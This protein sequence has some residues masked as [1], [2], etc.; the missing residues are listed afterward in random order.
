MNQTKLETVFSGIAGQKILI[1]AGASGIGYAIAETLH[2]LGAKLMICDISEDALDKAQERLEGLETIKADVSNEADVAQ[3]F[4]KLENRLGGLD[5]LINNAGIAGPTGGVEDIS[6]QDWRKCLDVCLTGQ[7][8]CTRLAVPLLKAAGAGSII[9]MSSAAG[10]HGYAFRTPYSSAKF[11]VI[12][13]TQSLAKEL[14]PHQIR[15]NAILPGVVEGERMEGV[16]HDR[17]KQLGISHEEM[18]AIY[19][20]KVSLRKMVSPYDMA[21]MVAFL[22]S[23]GGKNISGQSLSVD[24]NVE[25]L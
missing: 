15:V 10:K 4:E 1:T 17:A 6:P 5:A 14:G 16:I 3:M 9:N 25:T 2:G 22:L 21:A 23:D 8:L 7:F 18:K 19:L 11:G 13:F 12:G 24:G 20:E